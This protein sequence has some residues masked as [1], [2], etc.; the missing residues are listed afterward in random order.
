MAKQMRFNEENISFKRKLES[1]KLQMHMLLIV[2]FR[3]PIY[4][5]QMIPSKNNNP[6]AEIST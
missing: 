2:I 6:Q 3:Q 4:I 1:Y 5:F